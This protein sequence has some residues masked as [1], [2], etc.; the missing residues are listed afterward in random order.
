[1]FNSSRFYL[2]KISENVLNA[3]FDNF[4]Q[5]TL[6]NAKN[7]ILDL[8]GCAISGAKAKGNLALADLIKSWGGKEESTIFVYGGK[9]PAHNAAM[10]NSIMARSYDFE[11]I[12]AFVDGVDLPSHISVTTVM[13]ALS[14]GEAKNVN[15]KEL[16]TAL[17][18]GDDIACR[19]LAASNFSFTLGWD[20]NG[21]VNAFGATAVA[22]RLLGLTPSQMQN[23][24]GIVLNQLAGSFQNIWDGSLCFKFPNGLSARNGIFSAELAKAGWD[25][26]KDALFGK[27]GYFD[28]YT[29][30]CTDPDILIKDL[31][32]KYYTEATFKPY[33]CC[34]ANHA[35][36]DCALKIVN[37][38]KVDI[39]KIEE[40]IL[41]VP[42]RV[43]DMF[44]GQPFK[45]RENPQIDAAFNL[46]FCVANV[47]LRKTISIKHFQENYIKEPEISF[48]ANKVKVEGLESCELNKKSATLK[49]KMKDGKEYFAE[50]DFPKGGPVHN[51]LSKEEIQEKFLKN[52][53]F[54]KTISENNG[55]KIIS[56]IENLEEVENVSELIYLIAV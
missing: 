37:E 9:V 26:P 10:V 18:V 52:I 8:I 54:S 6:D 42:P 53:T 56:L 38:H 41:N 28:L 17:L 46:R 39:N 23:A 50:V 55:Q 20:G 11:A 16:I 34:R 31:G 33:P 51:S 22:G 19:I 4:D 35:A 2:E 5:K 13:T 3:C 36:I 30:G 49:V 44:V 43:R 45:V 24:F 15:G 29:E 25:G 40:I 27:Y 47:L 1:M 48:L 12:G 21:T 7:R 14:L 32:K